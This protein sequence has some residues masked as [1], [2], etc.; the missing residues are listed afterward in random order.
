[1]PKPIKKNPSPESG[2]QIIAAIDIGTNSIHLVVAS[3]NPR[4]L[5]KILDSDKVS[6]RLGQHMT[7]DGDIDR[8]GI[9]KTVTTMR[10]MKA[11]CAAWPCQIRAIA[12]HAVR[13]ARNHQ[14]LIEA[15][16]KATR[17]RIEVVDGD[18]EG[19]LVFLGMKRALALAN[20]AVLALDIGG[21]STEILFGRGD[22]INHVTS[23]NLGAVNLSVEH[24]LMKLVDDHT[25]VRLRE[26]IA[27]RLEP[28]IE[29]AKS[30]RF[31]VAVASSGTAK[32]LASI[33]VRTMRVRQGGDSNGQILRAQD[34]FAITAAL[35]QLRDPVLIRAK[36][37]LDVGRSEIIL[38]G[39]ELMSALTRGFG[40]SQW[41]LSSY[42]LREGAVI[43]TW[44]RMEFEKTGGRRVDH[45]DVREESIRSFVTKFQIE[46][47]AS[48]QTEK[49][50]LR[51]FDQ[52]SPWILGHV[53]LAD[54]K[55]LRQLLS[56]ATRIH[57]C[58]K[59]ISRQSFHRHSHHLIVHSHLLGFTLDE[60]NFMG[61]LARFHRKS[62]PPL[63]MD[64]GLAGDLAA[65][66]WAAMRIL[67]GMLRL[68]SALSRTVR[69]RGRFRD[70]VIK[71][72]GNLLQIGVV[73]SKS[74]LPVLDDYKTGKLCEALEKSWNIRISLDS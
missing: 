13:A 48:A 72:R 58:G 49:L 36:T 68:A 39:A 43:D 54:R 5:F 1:M 59:F 8:E 22:K 67:A 17:I 7:P 66:E 73:T 28:A 74:L 50:A 24:G 61:L 30:Q 31:Q 53:S 62:V 19:R 40:V 70:V 38:A 12:T 57:D 6:V 2:K 45:V 42:G 11:L 23:L 55:H 60:R 56:A 10:Q 34:L 47:S 9:R 4:G 18:E 64:G 29:G 33:N 51:I 26:G 16:F 63:V 69:T 15:V 37:G 20:K 32:S 25:L 14:Q 21:G 52:T 71:K 46:K 35:G 3:V 41:L 44:E 27:A 65:D